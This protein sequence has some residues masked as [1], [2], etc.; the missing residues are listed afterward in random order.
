VKVPQKYFWLFWSRGDLWK[1]REESANF[2]WEFCEKKNR[3]HRRHNFLS[4]K[5]NR[6]FG[7]K[8]S[9]FKLWKNRPDVKKQGLLLRVFHIVNR[10]INR[11]RTFQQPT[12]SKKSV[13][14]TIFDR[15]FIFSNFLP[16]NI[17][18]RAF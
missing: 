15:K 9:G 14:I 7:E 13:N 1:Q 16:F 17:L 2:L 6:T 4:P 5:K 10:F 12:K 11:C 3:F 18:P 8:S